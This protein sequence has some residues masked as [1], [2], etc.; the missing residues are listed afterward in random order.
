M[1][2]REEAGLPKRNVTSAQL[3]NW[4]L[5]RKT[6]TSFLASNAYVLLVSDYFPYSKTQ[7]AVFKGTERAVFLDKRVCL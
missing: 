2:Y 7:C 4:K 6:D 1:Q 3:V 5:L